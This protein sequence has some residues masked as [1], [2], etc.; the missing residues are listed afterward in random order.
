M[1]KMSTRHP[2]I[3]S[4]M[5][6]SR[7]GG[8]G[9]DEGGGGGER[10][11]DG[12]GKE[13]GGKGGGDELN[14]SGQSAIASSLNL[15][16]ADIPQVEVIFLSHLLNISKYICATRGLKFYTDV[17]EAYLSSVETCFYLS[18]CEYHSGVH[19]GEILIH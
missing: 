2:P 3:P 6:H 4:A 14:Q 11:G 9:G 19:Q 16:T 15:S 8:G 18:K 7:G 1:L 5:V 17:S 12:G 13:G 10:R